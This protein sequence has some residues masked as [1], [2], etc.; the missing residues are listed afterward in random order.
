[1][2]SP[3]RVDR[4]RI[5]RHADI[6]TEQA[7]RCIQTDSAAG[8]DLDGLQKIAN[9]RVD[10]PE[11]HEA[12]ALH[13]AVDRKPRLAVRDEERGASFGVAENAPWPEIVL[14]VSANAGGAAGEEL[15]ARDQILI[16]EGSRESYSRS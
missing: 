3:F 2:E 12:D 6:S 9:R 1:M 16:P 7:H 10:I 4:P 13:P 5:D 15:F 11:I 14:T 8:A